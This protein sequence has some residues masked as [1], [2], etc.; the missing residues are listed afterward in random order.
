MIGFDAI[1]GSS[2]LIFCVGKYGRSANKFHI[3][4]VRFREGRCQRTSASQDFQPVARP[5]VLAGVDGNSEA[6]P[7]A[8]SIGGSRTQQEREDPMLVVQ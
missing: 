6:F 5:R 8:N 1:L 2:E 4:V 7:E 3:E